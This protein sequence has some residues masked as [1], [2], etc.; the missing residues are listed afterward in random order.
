V[1]AYKQNGGTADYADCAD[2]ELRDH[3]ARGGRG[4]ARWVL[5]LTCS[6]VRRANPESGRI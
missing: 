4:R 3:R 2:F 5:R 1:S 6:A